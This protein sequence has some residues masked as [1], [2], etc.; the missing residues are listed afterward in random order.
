MISRKDMYIY[1]DTQRILLKSGDF[2]CLRPGHALSGYVSN[3]NITFP[4]K[5]LFLDGFTIIPSGCATINIENNGQHLSAYLDGPATKPYIIGSKNNQPEMLISIEFKPAGLYT[6]TGI[7]QNELTNQSIPLDAINSKLCKSLYES[8]EKSTTI[9]ELAA[10]LDSLLQENM[11]AANHPELGL[12]YQN[13]IASS[14]KTTIKELSNITHYSERQLTRIF[15]Q[16]IGISTKSFARLIRINNAFRL[17]KKPQNS[18]SFV[19]DMTGFHDL[20]HF[21]RDFKLVSGTTPQ[22]YRGNMSAFYN[23]TTRL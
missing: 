21:I 13:I 5:A 2:I 9:R 20:S 12:I 17:L 10:N 8:I 23:N 7:N 14:G 16:H 18:L 4:T 22:E 1:E 11:Y 19:S 15:N 6:F 3:Y